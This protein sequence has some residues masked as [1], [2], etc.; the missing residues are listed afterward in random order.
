MNL[1][2]LLMRGRRNRGHVAIDWRRRSTTL[3]S[4]GFAQTGCGSRCR[5]SLF[6]HPPCACESRDLPN[7]P[8]V[9]RPVEA[10]LAPGLIVEPIEN[11]A[12]DQLSQGVY[13]A[14]R[15]LLLQHRS[16]RIGEASTS[17][18]SR[19]VSI[20]KFGFGE[21]LGR[22]CSGSRSLSSSYSSSVTS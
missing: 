2:I 16:L 6:R 8:E 19:R 12:L 20:A 9:V 15:R 17:I 18:L 13:H 11:L 10:L 1:L 14:G 4:L 7:V 22:S 3:R 21:G 5:H